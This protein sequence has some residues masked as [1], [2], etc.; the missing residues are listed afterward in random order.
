MPA[1]L[2]MSQDKRG[3][4]SGPELEKGATASHHAGL[5]GGNSPII[6]SRLKP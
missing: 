6:F 4:L 5:S 2:M 3:R 1:S